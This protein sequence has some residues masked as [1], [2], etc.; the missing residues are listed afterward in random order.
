[1]MEYTTFVM[2]IQFVTPVFDFAWTS[3][4]KATLA[5]WYARACGG[6][7]FGRRGWAIKRM[8]AWNRRPSS[9]QRSRADR[10]AIPCI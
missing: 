4:S 9:T 8:D 1:M 5:Q 6:I 10:S 2:I 7:L 3:E